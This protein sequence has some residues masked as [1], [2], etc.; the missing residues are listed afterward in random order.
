MKYTPMMFYQSPDCGI[1]RE[2]LDNAWQGDDESLISEAMEFG[3]D[4]QDS[5]PWV[6]Y[7]DIDG[8]IPFQGRSF[9]IAHN[10]RLDY[11]GV[12]EVME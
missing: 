3:G 12:C 2:W 7:D 8:P 4:P 10:R 11:V 1:A 6:S 9:M 5:P